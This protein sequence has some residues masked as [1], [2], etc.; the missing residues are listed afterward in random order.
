[1]PPDERKPQSKG[2]KDG[3]EKHEEIAQNPERIKTLL[4]LPETFSSKLLKIEEKIEITF[5]GFLLSGRLDLYYVSKNTLF[6]V[7]WKTG[8]SDVFAQDFSQLEIYAFMILN[9]ISQK[10]LEEIQFIKLI[11]LNPDLKQSAEKTVNFSYIREIEKQL[12]DVKKNITKMDATENCRYCNQVAVCAVLKR[13]LMTTKNQKQ[14]EDW[15]EKDIAFLLV[16]DKIITD[17]KERLKEKILASKTGSFNGFKIK[18][19]NGGRVWTE[20]STPAILIK[21]LKIKNKDDIY[22]PLK[23]KTP[24]DLEKDYDLSG[25]SEFIGITTR[26]QIVKATM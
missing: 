9:S 25:V 18:I 14:I 7:D 22:Q 4:N 15:K 12:A 16:A 13:K 3:V 2:A 19:T 6:V 5:K 24:S 23:L 26:K 1:M 8:W 20:N 10:E 17:I 21:A 11:Y